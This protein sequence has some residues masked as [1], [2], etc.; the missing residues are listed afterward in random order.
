MFMAAAA[1]NLKKLLKYKFKPIQETQ[2][3]ISNCLNNLFDTLLSSF[4]QPY[5]INSLSW[6]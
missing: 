4:K 1:Y 2:K 5:A 6:F 3:Q